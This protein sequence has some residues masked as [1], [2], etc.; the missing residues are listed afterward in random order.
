M[1]NRITLSW[2]VAPVRPL[3][4][5]Q[6]SLLVARLIARHPPLCAD[7]GSASLRVLLQTLCDWSGDA[8]AAALH[9]AEGARRS[10]STHMHAPQ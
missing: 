8:P 10:R 3:P 2:Y 1:E 6:Q 7:V 5:A 9:N 4:S